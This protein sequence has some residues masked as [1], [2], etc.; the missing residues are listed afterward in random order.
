[1]KYE[2]TK[3][4]YVDLAYVMTPEE[5]SDVFIERAKSARTIR[6]I[7]KNLN[8][9]SLA[10]YKRQLWEAIVLLDATKEEKS[11]C[12]EEAHRKIKNEKLEALWNKIF[13]EESKWD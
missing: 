4:D 13:E 11:K 12:I 9:P 3:L 1:M 10:E 8:L 6:R 5:I 2:L 7:Y